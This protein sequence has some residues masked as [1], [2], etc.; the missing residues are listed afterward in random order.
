MEPIMAYPHSSSVK[1]VCTLNR[2]SPVF[3]GQ[4]SVLASLVALMVKNLPA[5][6]ETQV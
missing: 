3:K 2:Q 1:W 6:L 4:T 5:L